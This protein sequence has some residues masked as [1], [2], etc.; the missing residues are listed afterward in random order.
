MII[1]PL[2]LL[3]KD[4]SSL[5]FPLFPSLWGA[6]EARLLAEVGLFASYVA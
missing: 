3:C 6:V 1:P 5:L 4:G 2:L